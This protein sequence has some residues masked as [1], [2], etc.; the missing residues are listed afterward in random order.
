VL[1]QY[2]YAWWAAAMTASLSVLYGLLGEPADLHR[3]GE[4]LLAILVG[5]LCAVLPFALLSPVRTRAAVRRRL[6]VSLRLLGT[7]L[8]DGP[9]VQN[10]RAADHSLDELR[11]RSRPLR[12]TARVRPTAEAGWAAAL[13]AGVPA[14]HEVVL[15]PAGGGRTTL[16]SEVREV[17]AGLRRT[18]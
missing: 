13:V 18:Q 11:L 17:S 9:T 6:G 1:R 4:R 15:D 12:L 7:A 5:G 8:R 3:L 14:L 10:I 16:A 2:N